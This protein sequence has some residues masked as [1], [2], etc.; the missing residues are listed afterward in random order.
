M[1]EGIRARHAPA[2]RLAGGAG[3]LGGIGW[4]LLVPATELFRRDLLSYDAVNRLLAVPLLL[5]AVALAL[6]PRALPVHDGMARAGF[7]VATAGAALLFAGTVVEFYGVLLQDKL[8]A[9]AAWE[10][11]HAEHWIGSDIGWITFF[12]GALVLLVGGVLAAIGLARQHVQRRWLVWFAATLGVGV[13]A[14][15]LV[16]LE[17]GYLSVPVLGGYAGGWI[18]FGRALSSP[19]SSG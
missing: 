17:P 13:L 12:V 8:N 3:V 1:V 19:V 9:R 15:N 4:L 7:R 11:G 5:F 18:A 6:A 2:D 16:G 10:A 14:G